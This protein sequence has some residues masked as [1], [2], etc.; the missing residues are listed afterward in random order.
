MR[1]NP[2][3]QKCTFCVMRNG[4]AV[5]TDRLWLVPYRNHDFLACKYHRGGR[6]DERQGRDAGRPT[7]VL[8]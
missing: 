2:E 3:L 7:P 1:D 6:R 4:D 5:R 8:P